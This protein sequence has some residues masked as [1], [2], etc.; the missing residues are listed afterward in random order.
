[1]WFGASCTEWTSFPVQAAGQGTV[2]LGKVYTEMKD[3]IKNHS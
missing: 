3:C 2:A 1:M